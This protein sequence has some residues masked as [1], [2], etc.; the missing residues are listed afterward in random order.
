MRERLLARWW[1]RILVT[2]GGTAV[3]GAAVLPF[4][5]D[6]L[7]AQCTLYGALTAL[8]IGMEAGRKGSVWYTCGLYVGETTAR[9]ML[10]G[11]AVALAS[12]AVIALAA[13]AIGGT[14]VPAPASA[15]PLVG[16][17]AT[18]IVAAVGE[19]ILFRGTI[20][21]A[22]EERFGGTAAVLLTS[23]LFAAA[24]A[25][26]PDVSVLALVN[27]FFAGV[28]MGTMLMRS[29]S[30]WPSIFFHIVWNLLVALCFGDV[31]G[32]DLGGG[33]VVLD[34]SHAASSL[35]WLVSGSFGVEEGLL[36]TFLLVGATI[37]VAR[38]IPGSAYVVAA[39]YRRSHLE[40]LTITAS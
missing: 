40:A 13:L 28:L 23:L 9:E 35:Q 38:R 36:T 18:I 7:L 30:L 11:T 31:S 29:S 21:L 14:F 12:L 39:R 24:H 32:N 3:V 8:M 4:V 20:F 33:W 34:L 1:F 16:I 19:E 15:R 27:V 26:N 37:I 22:I 5:H 17:I 2:L 10:W 6:P 25:G